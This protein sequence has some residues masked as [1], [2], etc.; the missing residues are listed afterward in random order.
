MCLVTKARKTA[1]WQFLRTETAYLWQ[2]FGLGT[3]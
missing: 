3:Q 2:E 1:E